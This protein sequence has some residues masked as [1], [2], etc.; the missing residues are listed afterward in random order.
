ME[1]PILTFKILEM[2]KLHATAINAHFM[3]NHYQIDLDAQELNAH[4][5][6]ILIRTVFVTHVKAIHDFS[7]LQMV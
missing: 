7:N 3:N 1:E 4:V 6:N 5:I 2:V